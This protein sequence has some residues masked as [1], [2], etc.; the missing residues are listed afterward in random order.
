[1]ASLDNLLHVWRQSTNFLMTFSEWVD[2]QSIVIKCRLLE[3]IDN[4]I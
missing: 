3:I 1:M 4:Q 2:K